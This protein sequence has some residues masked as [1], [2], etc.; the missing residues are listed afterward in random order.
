MRSFA[1][2]AERDARLLIVGSMPGAESL[3]QGQYYA[4]PRNAFWRI[5]GALFGFDPSAAYGDRLAGLTRAGVALWDVLGRCRREGSLDADIT[6]AAPNDLEGLLAKCPGIRLVGCNGGAAHAALRR[7][8]PRF[9]VRV[10]RLPSTSPAAAMWSEAEKLAMW[11]AALGGGG[12]PHFQQEGG[13]PAAARQD[14]DGEENGVRRGGGGGG[15][16]G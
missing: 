16:R 15:C 14:G 2:V 13:G 4:F 10:V 5:T 7:F 11:R 8:F 12:R 6:D 1:A 3:R 9:P